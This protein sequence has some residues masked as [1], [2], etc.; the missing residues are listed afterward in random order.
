MSRE[1]RKKKETKKKI[2]TFEVYQ[3]YNEDITGIIKKILTR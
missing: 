2:E 3:N 1:K